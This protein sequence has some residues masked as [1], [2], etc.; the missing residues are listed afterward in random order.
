MSTTDDTKRRPRR[1]N[2]Y[3]PDPIIDYLSGAESLSG[4]VTQI[5]G[6]YRE[7]L[8]R[9]RVA[10]R[11]DDGEMLTIRQ[12]C[13][14]WWSEPAATIFGGIALELEDYGAPAELV[15]KV[16]AMTPWEQVALLEYVEGLSHAP[17]A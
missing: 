13:H 1:Q 14:G 16:A 10:D 11:F 8:R 12:A 4:R 17:S 6:R 3:F 2:V 5:I 15:S 9:T 7:A